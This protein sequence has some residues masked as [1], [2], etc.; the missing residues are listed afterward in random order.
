VA[1]RIDEEIAAMLLERERSRHEFGLLRRL[2][3]L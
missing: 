3:T 1:D 2:A